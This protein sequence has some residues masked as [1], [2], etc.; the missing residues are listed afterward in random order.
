MLRAF[1]RLTGLGPV[2]M[3]SFAALALLGSWR[4]L[5]TRRTFGTALVSVV[6]AQWVAVGALQ[7]FGDPSAWSRYV[8]PAWIPHLLL[9]AVG[10]EGLLAGLG[11]LV[12][13]TLT[14]QERQALLIAALIPVGTLAFSL[15][16]VF[17]WRRNSFRTLRET[18]DRQAAEPSPAPVYAFLRDEADAG[19]TVL[20]CGVAASAEGWMQYRRGQLAHGKWVRL[21]SL[22][23]EVQ[24]TT[25]AHY[26]NLLPLEDERALE[27]SGARYL[28]LHSLPG[29]PAP[30]ERGS[31][32]RIRDQRIER[33]RAELERR[34]GAPVWAGERHVVFDLR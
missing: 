9:V 3:V 32:R 34:Y 10:L 28:V 26:R 22:G 27:A 24:L 33:A 20:E 21:V 16:P 25:G 6:V 15:I 11:R 1:A 19:D 23:G 29:A 5:A 18:L 14:A 13:G 31:R 12:P 2:G 8:F 30:A 17:D 4:A 7:P